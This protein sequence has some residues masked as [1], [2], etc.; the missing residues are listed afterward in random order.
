MLFN[1]FINGLSNLASSLL[2]KEPIE[3][4]IKEFEK[5]SNSGVIFLLVEPTETGGKEIG[6]FYVES[7]EYT[8]SDFIYAN[9]TQK[10]VFKIIFR[11]YI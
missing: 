6:T 3:A 10:T 5:Y 8:Q 11:E 1:E 4:E 2:N 9:K 7:F